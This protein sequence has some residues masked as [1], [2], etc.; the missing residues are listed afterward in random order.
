MK[1]WIS[2]TGSDVPWREEVEDLTNPEIM[3]A[4]MVGPKLLAFERKNSDGIVLVNLNN[5]TG[6]VLKKED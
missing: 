4:L 1:L 2:K 3:D 5:I 6:L